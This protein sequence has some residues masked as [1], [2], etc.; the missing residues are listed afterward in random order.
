M[1]YFNSNRLSTMASNHSANARPIGNSPS[2]QVSTQ[3]LLNAL[4]TSF[5]NAQ[6]HP[7]EPSTSLV[8]NTWETAYGVG[9]DGRIGG[10]ADVELA[11]KAWEHARRR[12]EDG[13]IILG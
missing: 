9:P 7:L 3:S 1:D 11:R 10:T 13:C 6:P 8:V 4:H 12:A 5:Q 2:S